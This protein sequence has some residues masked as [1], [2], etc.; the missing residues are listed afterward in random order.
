M[1]RVAVLILGGIL[2][3]NITV[4]TFAWAQHPAAGGAG[5][6]SVFWV[7]CLGAFFIL[8]RLWKVTP[9]GSSLPGGPPSNGSTTR[10]EHRA[11]R[12]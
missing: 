5:I 10:S 2:A 12:P 9:G 3:G 11:E 8:F 4:A 7:L 6:L 1:R